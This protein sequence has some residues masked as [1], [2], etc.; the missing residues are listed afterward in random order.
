[1]APFRPSQVGAPARRRP[2]VGGILFGFPA[3]AADQPREQIAPMVVVKRGPDR[4]SRSS[5]LPF[6][7]PSYRPNVAITCWRTWSLT[8]RLLDDLQIGAPGLRRK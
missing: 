2:R 1:V 7:N 4:N 3:I 8:R 5:C 6:C